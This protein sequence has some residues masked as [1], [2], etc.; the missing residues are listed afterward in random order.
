MRVLILTQWYPPE[1]MKLL[2]DMAESLV[3]M[4]HEVTVLTGLPNWPTGKIYPGYRRCLVRRETA[5]GVRI[6]RIPLYPDHSVNPFKRAANFLSFAFS[7]AVLGPF[8]VP[9]ADVMHVVHPPVTVGFPAWIL[10]RLRGFPFTMEIQDM[11]PENLRSTGMLRNEPALSLIGTL[12]R[13]VYS[14]AAFVRVISPGFRLNLLRK[15]VPDEKIRVISNWVDTDYYRPTAKLPDLLDRFGMRERFNVLYAGTIGLAQ[16][17]EVVLN[18]AARLQVSSPD[19]QFLLAGDGVEYGRLRAEAITRR[20]TN[21]RFLGRLPGDLMPALYACADV[22]MLHLRADPLFAITVPHK[23]FTY[24]ASAKPILFGGEGDCAALVTESRAG[25]VFPP[26]NAEA[27][28]S[29]V[30]KLHAMS[31]EAREEMGN[32]G[33]LPACRSYSRA[34]L[35]RDLFQSMEAA[36]NW[37]PR[38]GTALSIPSSNGHERVLFFKG[39]PESAPTPPL[40]PAG[41]EALFWRP[42]LTR[43]CPPGQGFNPFAVWW[44]FHILRVFRN[45]EFGVFLIRH[46]S[47]W[48]HC[49]VV[50]PRYF[51]FPFMH[52]GDLQVGDVWTAENERGRGLASFAL[53][54][55]LSAD[56]DRQRPYWHLVDEDNRASIR[57]AERANFRRTAVGR[58]T[59]RF[60]VRFLGAYLIRERLHE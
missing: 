60:G 8:L 9:R 41:Y 18:A 27:L 20:L 52:A 38:K 47:Q 33:R 6:I 2:S 53:L 12:A 37:R 58:R 3:A 1:P 32:N 48:V 51:R 50:T 7:A 13:W 43:I 44:L 59:S 55:I 16:G 54:S 15:G 21:V 40:L 24:L 4:G 57:V 10:S 19:S 17:L 56:S 36:A 23:V 45:R 25:L 11:W 22:L 5:N 46:A 31:P 34:Y 35:V 30:V 39:R 29:S 26:G 28:A 49:S 42:S 14:K